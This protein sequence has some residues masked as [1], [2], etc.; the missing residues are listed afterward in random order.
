LSASQLAGEASA[1]RITAS[2]AMP[3][4]VAPI[5]VSATPASTSGRD[6]GVIG[7]FPERS[8]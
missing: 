2:Q 6:S 3:M 1:A 5:S 7:L 4:Q 8:R